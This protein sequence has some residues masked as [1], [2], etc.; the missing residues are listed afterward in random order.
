MVEKEYKPVKILTLETFVEIVE[1]F[2]DKVQKEPNNEKLK[3]MHNS[4]MLS[5]G[6]LHE[7]LTRAYKL[8][9]YNIEEKSKMLFPY[10]TVIEVDVISGQLLHTWTEELL[11]RLV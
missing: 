8:D 10:Q 4:N 5:Q 6:A 2:D 1:A 9:T 11:S 7:I 3:K